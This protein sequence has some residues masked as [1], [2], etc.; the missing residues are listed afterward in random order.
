MTSSPAAMTSLPMPSAGMAAI[1]YSR[2]SPLIRSLD[3]DGSKIV[4]VGVGRP[5]HDEIVDAQEERIAVI[6]G[7][8]RLG[9][10]TGSGGTR[11][12]VGR[13][14]GTGIVLGAVDPVGVG[15]QSV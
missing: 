15:G 11:Q 3:D 2:I 9:D 4:D 6:V 5:G 14:D 1:L 8:M 13:D 7:E 10:E 12:R